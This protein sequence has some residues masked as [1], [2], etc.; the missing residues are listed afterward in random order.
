MISSQQRCL[1]NTCFFCRNIDVKT[2]DNGDGT[3]S[4]Y[5][6][7]LEPGEYTVNIKYGGQSI[8]GGTHNIVVKEYKASE[9]LSSY[10]NHVHETRETVHQDLREIYLNNIPLLT[11]GGHVTGK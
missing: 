4:I 11:T 10:E 2:V 8:P 1:L 6:S 5:F 9:K 7:I 3:I